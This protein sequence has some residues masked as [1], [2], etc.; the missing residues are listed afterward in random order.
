MEVVTPGSPSGAIP[1][2]GA[3]NTGGNTTQTS[4]SQSATSPITLSDDMEVIPPGRDKPVKYGEYFKSFQSQFTKTAQERADLQRQLEAIKTE[5]QRDTEEL[6]RLR[7]SQQPAA[8]QDPRSTLI[9]KIKSLPYLNGQDAA[10]VVES[11]LGE[12]SSQQQAL[13]MRDM[14]IRLLNQRFQELDKTVGQ[15]SNQNNQAGFKSKMETFRTQLDLPVE[16]KEW[17]EELYLA[18]EGD[19]LDQE[20]PKIAKGRWEQLQTLL[21]AQDQNKVQQARTN[22]FTPPKG[23]NGTPNAPLDFSKMNPKQMADHLWASIQGTEPT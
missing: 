9:S 8:G 11:I 5:R 19:D 20:F 17:L 22:R 13:Q 7:Q 18:Y 4:T 21:R 6:Q 14:A 1:A 2:E 12:V 3:P 23:G 10:E 15:L 16:A